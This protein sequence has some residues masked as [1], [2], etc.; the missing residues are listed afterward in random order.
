MEHHPGEEAGEEL[1]CIVTPTAESR[2]AGD[3]SVD[4]HLE[5][6]PSSVDLPPISRMPAAIVFSKMKS[7]IKDDIETEGEVLFQLRVVLWSPEVSE[8]QQ[9]ISDH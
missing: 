5:P 1:V 7:I 8:R 2:Q 3:N 6:Q 4:E 9:R